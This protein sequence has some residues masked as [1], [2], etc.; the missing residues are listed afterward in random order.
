ML[1][2]HRRATYAQDDKGQYTIVASK[3]WEVE[4]V[5]N[6]QAVE[7]MQSEIEAMRQRA[8]RGEVSPLAFHMV[9]C[10]MTPGLL[11]ANSGIW[12]WRVNRHL[13]VDGFAGLNDKLLARYAE[14][15]GT[16]ITSLKSIPG[17]ETAS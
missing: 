1:G 13:T 17:D 8:L 12:R 3:G 11:A 9:R 10:H 16:D 4:K 7:A 6:G 15:L 2:E 14:T 5:V